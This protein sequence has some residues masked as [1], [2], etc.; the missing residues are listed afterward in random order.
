MPA[1]SA[2]LISGSMML[3][4][5]A[6]PDL[7]H[8]EW[9]LES[10]SQPDPRPSLSIADNQISGF[11]GCNRFTLGLDGDGKHQVASTRKLCAPEVMQREHALLK[12]LSAPFQLLPDEKL[13]HLTLRAGKQQYRFARSQP[14]AD[15]PPPFKPAAT[16]AEAAQ[17]RLGE[18]Y[19]YVASQPCAGQ[20]AGCLQV[21]ESESG[22][23]REYRGA[24]AGFAPEAGSS[25]YLKLQ[26]EANDGRLALQLLKVVYQENVA[27]LAD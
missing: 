13:Q 23:W 19:W 27:P 18:Q 1:L 3:P 22:P 21:R 7:Q 26:G 11:S 17:P 20:A 8:T 9:L 5:Q 16:Q 10:P 14:T 25:Y 15:I 24:I 6:M 4:V 2:I 12:L